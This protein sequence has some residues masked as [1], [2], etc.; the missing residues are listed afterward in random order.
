MTTDRSYRQ[1]MTHE[2]ALSIL[3]DNAGI[4]FDPEI[5]ATFLMLPREILTDQSFP[6]NSAREIEQF[7]TVDVG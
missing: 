1:G 2:K 5:V 7:E 3:V 6:D 4:Q